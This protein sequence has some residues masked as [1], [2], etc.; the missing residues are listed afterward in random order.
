MFQNP[1]LCY[2]IFKVWLYISFVGKQYAVWQLQSW[3]YS[4]VVVMMITGIIC[5]CTST[6]KTLE[7]IFYW[8]KTS[9]YIWK[10]T[11]FMCTELL[12]VFMFLVFVAVRYCCK[13][14]GWKRMITVL[15]WLEC[16]SDQASLQSS[17][18]SWN[19]ILRTWLVWLLRSRNGFLQQG[20]RKL[21]GVPYLS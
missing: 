9:F 4:A 6:S 21:S 10:L 1:A 18:S 16:F 2:L 19:Q 8:S 5:I 7:N 11:F 12:F 14:W 13:R 15:V 3:F 20:G 17:I